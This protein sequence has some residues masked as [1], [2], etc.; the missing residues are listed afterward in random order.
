M[1]FYD[2]RKEERKT[3]APMIVSICIVILIA[4]MILIMVGIVYLKNSITTIRI[5]GQENTD[6]ENLLYIKSTE[7]GAKLY[8]PII[9]MAE[10]L[11]YKGFNGDYK[12]KSEDKTKCHVTGENETAMFSL[13]SDVLVKINKNSEIEYVNIDEPVFEVN[14]ELYTTING[15]EKAFNVLFAY[16]NKFKNIEIYS[17]NYLIQYYA[18]QL[19]LGEGSYST[20]FIDQKAIFENMIVIKENDQYGVIDIATKKPVLETKYQEIK[21]LPATSEFLVK[22]NGKYGVMTKEAT[23]KIKT[24]YDEIKAMDN[25]NGLYLVKQNNSYGVIDTEG[26]VKIEPEY[27]EIGIKNIDNYAQNGVENQ[28]VLLDKIIPVKNQDNLWGFFNIKGEKISDFK[29]TNI[30]CLT[31]PIANS[32]PAIVIPSY[33]IIVV[34]SDKKYNLVTIDGEEMISGNI[35]DSVYLKTNITTGENEFFMTSSNNTKVI[36][37]GEWLTSIGE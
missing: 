8:M 20:E 31:T 15:I 34:Q 2:E 21:Y 19:Q 37:I 27:I 23:T 35:L 32:Y 17:M 3:K 9:K 18:T 14:G 16:D 22:S 13:D 1:E 36:N 33:K 24:I 10:H 28:W 30:G 7:D 11:N 12:N 25:Q 26:N 5:D 4:I 6:I 29:Y